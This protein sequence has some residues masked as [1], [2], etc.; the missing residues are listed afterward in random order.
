MEEKHLE[1][2]RDITHL[3]MLLDGQPSQSKCFR[4][5]GNIFN[6]MSCFNFWG[7]EMCSKMCGFWFLLHLSYIDIGGSMSH[8][9]FS[10]TCDSFLNNSDEA[11][12]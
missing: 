9:F 5:I 6:G 10:K 1:P 8:Q 4:S 11:W 3:C 12:P 7:V 2:L